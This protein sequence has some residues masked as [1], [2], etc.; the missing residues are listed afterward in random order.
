MSIPL[1]LSRLHFPVTA[2][3]PGQRVG[4]WFQGC[5]IRCAGCISADTW[6]FEHG[7]TTVGAVIDAMGEWLSMADG[8]TISGGE[9]FDQA[10]ALLHLLRAVRSR[11]SGDIL[12]YTGHAFEAMSAV[13]AQ[14]PGLIDVLISGPYD[15]S[16]SQSFPLRGS[17]NQRLHFLS[18]LG[19]ERFQRYREPSLDHE[20]LLDVMFDEWG[21]AWFAGIP[22][23][24]DFML[25]RQNLGLDGHRAVTSED[26]RDVGK[27]IGDD[28]ENLPGLQCST[29]AN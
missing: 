17:D 11:F 6:A 3:G 10:D 4:V 26:N 14:A 21:T 27:N 13:I 5:S 28:G 1:F 16:A 12:V 15:A 9:P 22:K 18:N 24:G 20:Q 23:R 7:A 8:V 25:L 19:L 29:A 2:L